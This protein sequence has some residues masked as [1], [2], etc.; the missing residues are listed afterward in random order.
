MSIKALVFDF[1]GVL[2]FSRDE[3]MEITMAKHLNIP[4]KQVGR[5]FHGEFN[6]RVDIGEFTSRDFWLHALDSM[7][8]PH[9]RMPEVENFFEEEFF[10][11][12]V[13]L[14][15]VRGY[16]Q[17][18]K[19]AMLSN[20]S[21][22]LRPSLDNRWDVSGAFDEIIISWEVKMI[23][24]YPDIFDFTLK[25]LQVSREEAVLIDDRIVNISGA[26]DYGMHA[27]HFRNRD[28][29]LTE[30]DKLI[31]ANN[32]ELQQLEDKIVK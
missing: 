1:F 11:D 31:A 22:G 17:N 7:G 30:L 24:P 14:E 19:T 2:L 10:L 20:Y 16:H 18:F 25:K 21:D 4:V 15:A 32:S 8:L 29:A 13:M 3:S 12:P 6:D 27:V 9:S 23:K 26:L 28:Q 5:I